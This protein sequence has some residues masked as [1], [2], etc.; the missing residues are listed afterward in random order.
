MPKKPTVA[1]YG[2]WPEMQEYVKTKLKGFS[3]LTPRKKSPKKI[4]IRKPTF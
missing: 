4:L 1:F 2:I 3:V